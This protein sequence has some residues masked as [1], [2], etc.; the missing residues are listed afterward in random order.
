[1]KVLAMKL[2][3]K[4]SVILGL[5]IITIVLVFFSLYV[6]AFIDIVLIILLVC[7]VKSN[8]FL[9]EKIKEAN[10]NIFTE[11]RRNFDYVIIGD[12]V[13]SENFLDNNS[14]YLKFTAPNRTLYGSF[15]ILQNRFSWLREGGSCIIVCKK[16]NIY[17]QRIIPFDIPF[18]HPIV[19]KKYSLQKE[20]KLL[21]YPLFYPLQTILFL[22][23][24]NR[25]VMLQKTQCPN[26]NIIMFCKNRNIK[27]K[28]YE[29]I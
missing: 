5:L 28:Y 8:S 25:K 10:P 22:F 13:G 6:I 15:M 24:Q 1:M 9:S 11:H 3:K 7:L 23:C 29:I 21:K 20:Q 17:K 4:N 12:L 27:L 16:Q 14:S 19:I 26:M 2:N 18:F